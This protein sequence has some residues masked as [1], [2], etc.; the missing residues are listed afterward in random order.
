MRNQVRTMLFIGLM[1]IVSCQNYSKKGIKDTDFNLLSFLKD[2]TSILS[3]V[4]NIAI[5]G[6][7]KENSTNVCF[8]SVPE[9]EFFSAIDRNKDHI[10]Y[11]N[12]HIKLNEYTDNEI[13]SINDSIIK[14]E[15]K[16]KN[17]RLV[18]IEENVDHRA[19]KFFLEDKIGSYYVIK[20]IQ[21]EDA[22]TRFWNSKT[23]IYDLILIGLSACI[24]AKDSLIFY[25]NTFKVMPEE[26][27]AVCLMKVLPDKID[28]LLCKNVDW[29]TGF[30]FFDKEDSSIYY[31]HSFYEGGKL[32][33]TYAKMIFK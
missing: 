27:T 11:F 23:G 15:G 30:S 8:Y 33:S 22:E 16:Y 28:T 9:E 32:K 31:I 5:D 18:D 20:Q 7:L 2:S 13:V 17:I 24:S 14:I 4:S 29:F 3:N 21:F 26:E 12:R 1:I 6:S 25:S 19:R 10:R